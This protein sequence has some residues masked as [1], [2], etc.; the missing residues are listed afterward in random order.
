M[1]KTYSEIRQ[2]A[3][4]RAA[5]ELYAVAAE[6]A[7]ETAND[8]LD[9]ITQANLVWAASVSATTFKKAQALEDLGHEEAVASTIQ[10]TN[11]RKARQAVYQA[12][13]RLQA[14]AKGELTLSI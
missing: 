5:R 3:Y 14:H 7:N 2:A 9:A 10:E 11:L 8:P 6:V 1:T 12:Q 4:F 13:K